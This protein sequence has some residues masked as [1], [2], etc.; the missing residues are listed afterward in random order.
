MTPDSAPTSRART[1]A[2]AA[3]GL[4]HVALALYGSLLVLGESS[5]LTLI[6][7]YLP[8]WPILVVA[9]AMVA[10][11]RYARRGARVLLPLQ[12]AI[13]LLLL[14]PVA[15]FNVAA[16]RRADKPIRLASYNVF[17]AQMGR[18][19]LIDELAAMPADLIVL[20]AANEAL[21]V[22]AADRF[23]SRVV[24]LANEE[25]LLISRYP[26]LAVDVPPDLP[27]GTPAMFVTFTVETPDGPLR[28]VDVHPFSPRY[29]LYF[30]HAVDQNL[31]DREAQIEAAVRAAKASGGPF[32]VVGDTNLPPLSAIGRRQL[33]GLADAWNEVGFGLGYTFPAGHS[34]MRIDRAL[35][36]SR[37]RFLDARVG[38]G[39]R[40]DH[41]PL[42]VE[43]A[44][45]PE[46]E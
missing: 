45:A 4:Q 39:G 3:V 2:L 18:A 26:L 40:S 43:L 20:Q 22:R 19:A 33:A 11:V 36:G 14:F 23:P 1:L 31:H 27:D 7:V 32:V 25:F 16:S 21:R 44:I 10:A 29:A 6:V 8:R 15:G 12:L 38:R 24:K 37:I 13:C 17:F 5:R 30:G 35:G 28:I 41:L 46:H 34:W 9:I 42:F